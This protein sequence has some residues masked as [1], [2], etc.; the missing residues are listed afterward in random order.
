MAMG[1]SR[2]RP[3]PKNGMRSSERLRSQVCG[4]NR[5]WRAR[6]SHIDSWRQSTTDASRGRFPAPSTTKRSPHVAPTH[7][8]L[9]R[10][11]R[12]MKR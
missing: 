6:V 3:Q 2:A 11:Q 12:V 4:A 8:R 10:L 1:R 5:V 7:H 9:N